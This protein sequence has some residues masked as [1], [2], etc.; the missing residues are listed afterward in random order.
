MTP[1]HVCAL[2]SQRITQGCALF[3]K[4]G[5]QICHV[6]FVF[7]RYN[8]IHAFHFNSSWSNWHRR[9]M[10]LNLGNEDEFLLKNSLSSSELL[11]A[12][13]D[14]CCGVTP[15]QQFAAERLHLF[16]LSPPV[17]TAASE[18]FTCTLR[19]AYMYQESTAVGFKK[20]F[21][22]PYKYKSFFM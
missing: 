2:P 4:L 10:Q 7:T 17:N 9:N 1:A 16:S 21:H 12:D 13:A 14:T 22:V 5:H 11:V 8:G 15:C 18:N 3:W 19:D 6:R 20:N